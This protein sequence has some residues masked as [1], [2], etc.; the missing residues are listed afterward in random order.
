MLVYRWTNALTRR[1]ARVPEG[2]HRPSETCQSDM[3]A[4]SRRIG[5]VSSVQVRSGRR[6][7]DATG[8]S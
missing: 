8:E 6:Y 5:R 4:G 3:V 1:A 7:S 2:F